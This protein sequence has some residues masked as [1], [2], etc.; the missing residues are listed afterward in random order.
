MAC[1]RNWH[2]QIFI[3]VAEENVMLSC[4][5]ENTTPIQKDLKYLNLR[6]SHTWK[7][8]TPIASDHVDL[9][10]FDT[11]LPNQ[12]VTT[13]RF[14]YK[15][16]FFSTQP[17]CGLT[18]S[19]IMLQMLL[20]CCLTHISIIILKHFLYLVYLCSWLGRIYVIYVIVSIMNTDTFFLLLIFK[21]TFYYFWM[22]TWWRM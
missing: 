3:R 21:S 15:Q 6:N 12:L 13:T 14:F 5:L 8:K 1:S 4:K 7:L 16:R 18:F 22:I 17:H 2:T 10:K 20:R 9:E 11:S 19:W